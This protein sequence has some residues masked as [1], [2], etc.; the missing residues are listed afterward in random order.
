[1]NNPSGQA[2]APPPPPWLSTGFTQPKRATRKGPVLLVVLLVLAALTGGVGIGWALRG[3]GTAARS[4]PADDSIGTVYVESNI[5][6][7]NGN[8]ILALRYGEGGNL[9][10][11]Q[12]RS[13]PTGGSGSADLSDSGVLD[14]DQHLVFDA[15]HRLLFAVNQGSDTIAV[16]HVLADG[17]LTAVAGSPFP[18]G[19][20]APASVGISGDRLV[21]VNKAQDGIRDLS[22]VKPNYTTFLVQSDGSLKPTGSTV[23]APLGFSPTQA[24]ISTNG[25]V[26]LSSEEGGPFRAMTL[27]ADGTLV[28]G[29][30]SPLSPPESIFPARFPAA[31]KWALGLGVNPNAPLLYAEMATVSK[32]AVF[33]YDDNA[34]LTFV[35]AVDN[36]G[37]D[38]PCWTLVNKAGTRVYT[39]NAG[40]NTM[41]VFDISD[42]E[43]P[44]QIQLL[45]LK[46]DG[47]PW[48]LHFDPTE[49]FIFMIDPR[50]TTETPAGKG[51]ELHTLLVGPDG[52]L[53][54]PNYSPVPIP[55]GSNTEPLG[56]AVVA[57]D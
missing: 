4:A 39:D 24:L 23:E 21:V 6:T 15:A 36:P 37:S 57:D 30:N 9:A 3:D 28:Q 52:T 48:D 43:Q 54:E 16:F 40:N 12:V 31:K 50:A 51:N 17:S 8:T 14:A 7:P 42:P 22:Q 33:R 13:Y 47:N 45:K 1:V 18:S 34:R 55:V 2:S 41:S 11:L 26:V 46:H 38:L 49:Q 35:R 44:R 10:P 32:L 20:A 53:T 56:V 5:A 19:G 29:S 25:N 27:A